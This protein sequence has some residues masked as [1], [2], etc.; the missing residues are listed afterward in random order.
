LESAVT[1][2]EI[3]TSLKLYMSVTFLEITTAND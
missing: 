1:T 2:I 3:A